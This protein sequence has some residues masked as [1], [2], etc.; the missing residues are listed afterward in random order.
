[1]WEPGFILDPNVT[2]HN[3]PLESSLTNVSVELVKSHIP[4]VYTLACLFAF[5]VFGLAYFIIFKWVAK[6]SLDLPR[7]FQDLE[8]VLA[9]TRSRFEE[10]TSG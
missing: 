8:F 4:L 3:P 2:H 7:F 6:G 5:L 1:M 10:R 9:E